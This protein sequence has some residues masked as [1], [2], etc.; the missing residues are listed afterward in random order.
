MSMF[1]IATATV[2]GSSTTT[3]TFSSIPQTFTHLEIRAVFNQFNNVSGNSCYVRFNGDSGTNYNSH[4]LLGTGSAVVSGNYGGSG[5][6]CWFGN[7]PTNISQTRAVTVATILD[8]TNT[9][10]A[11]VIKVNNG[12]DSNTNDIQGSWIFS[13]LWTSTAAITSFSL[14]ATGVGNYFLA[15]AR[16]DLYGI[17]TSNATGA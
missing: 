11:K 5:P 7:Y 4:Y 8:Y 9:N 1:P 3:V 15:G 16:F 2:S 6:W 17:S 10:K 14:N 12:Y 13:G